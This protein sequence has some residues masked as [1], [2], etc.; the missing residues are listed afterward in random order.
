M[1]RNYITFRLYGHQAPN[2]HFPQH[3]VTFSA[4]VMYSVNMKGFNGEV[5][6]CTLFTLILVMSIILCA[7]F[8]YIFCSLHLLMHVQ[9]CA[10]VE[11]LTAKHVI[12]MAA[13]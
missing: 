9:L 2:V 12:S 4:C 1:V 5:C 8:L 11:S 10:V 6:D 7:K 3:D 13:K